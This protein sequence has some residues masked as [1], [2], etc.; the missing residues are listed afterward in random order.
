MSLKNEWDAAA[1]GTAQHFV[2][3][4]G[5]DFRSTTACAVVLSC[6]TTV[7]GCQNTVGDA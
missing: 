1:R 2:I 7:I 3:S 6:E 4:N 5:H